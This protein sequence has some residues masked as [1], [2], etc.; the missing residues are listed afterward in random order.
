[1][2]LRRRDARDRLTF[3]LVESE[4][5]DADDDALGGPGPVS[6][7][8]P[9]GVPSGATG[10]T[11]WTPGV[12]AGVRAALGATDGPAGPDG[13]PRR[14]S[15][16]D[17][18]AEDDPAE[19]DPAESDPAEGGPPRRGRPAAVVA[20]VAAGVALVLGGMLTVD[21][22]QG[23]ADVE[24][25]RAAPGGLEPLPDAPV[26]RWT[27]DVEVSGGLALLP[28]AVVTVEDGTAVARS[29]DDG[30]ERWRVDVGAHASC[31]GQL[32]WS[33]PFG[34]PAST[35][36]CVAPSSD[37]VGL[38]G[39]TD[40]QLDPETGRV[41]A[42]DWAVTVLAADGEVLGRRDTTSAGGAPIPGTDGT[43][44]RAQRVGEVPAGDGAVVEQDVATGEVADL[45]LGRPAV[46]RV[47][48][49][50]TGDTR[51]EADVPFVEGSG[52]CVGWTEADGTET[53][54]AELENLWAATETHLVR[55]EG[56]GVTA[57][58]TPGGERLD[59]QEN[60]LDG[61]VALADGTYYRDPSGYAS[62]WG[63]AATAPRDAARA[64]LAADGAVRW[65][66]PGP[67]LVPRSSDGSDA[68]LLTRSEG[69]LVAFDGDGSELWRS[70]EVVAP[71]AVL[72]ATHDTV[73]VSGGS[74]TGWMTGLDATTGTVRWSLDRETVEAAA[75]GSVSW[76]DTA[77]TDGR[78]AILLAYQ[79]DGRTDLLAIDLADGHVAWSGGVGPEEGSWPVPLQGRLLRI[80]Q[81]EIARLG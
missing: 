60:P 42:S 8:G 56:C 32:L 10:G 66:P 12:T 27:A 40:L 48:D 77:Y 29:L 30:A 6:P 19:S 50:L 79:D 62:T 58:F 67:I 57:W 78:R 20:G 41:L 55:V 38:G 9:R 14:A 45:P 7:G 70:S 75:G 69:E 53:I 15:V 65:E 46:V 23:R 17:D 37:A 11:T 74:S 61:V 16:D 39:V 21:A 43:L 33:L 3:E 5:V 64:V 1:M 34:E 49:A 25:L 51:W 26:E 54:R 80:G 44:L 31:G 73:V 13:P 72:V 24:R 76:M 22:W 68:P 52:Q 71:E 63:S 47:E 59:D 4:D 28:G 2:P 36:V 35:L 81:S 18:P